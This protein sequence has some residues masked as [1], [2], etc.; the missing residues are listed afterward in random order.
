ML[1]HRD[2]L[3]SAHSLTSQG[4]PS[5]PPKRKKARIDDIAPSRAGTDMPTARRD[6]TILEDQLSEALAQLSPDVERHR[7]GRGPKRERCMSY[8]DNDILQPGL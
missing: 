1:Q 4:H 2:A 6:F 8:W 3:H 5:L 7:K